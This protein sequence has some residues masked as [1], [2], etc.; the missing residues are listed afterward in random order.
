MD[1]WRDIG[2]FFPL[3][4]GDLPASIIDHL[5]QFLSRIAN[6]PGTALRVALLRQ[7]AVPQGWSWQVIPM[8]RA[9][10]SVCEFLLISAPAEFQ[11]TFPLSVSISNFFGRWTRTFQKGAIASFLSSALPAVFRLTWLKVV[12]LVVRIGMVAVASIASWA[13]M[14]FCAIWVL[15]CHGTSPPMESLSQEAKRR[16]V[17]LRAGGSILRREPGGSP[18]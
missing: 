3:R 9:Y 13:G 15:S 14:I 8:E 10:L 11:G 1:I 7:I 17:A 6:A 12:Q 4:M 16:R 2:L 18:P 5:G